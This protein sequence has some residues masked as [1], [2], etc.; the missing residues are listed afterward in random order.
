MNWASLVTGTV[1]LGLLLVGMYVLARV[2]SV[3]V[4][5]VTVSEKRT[6]QLVVYSR[7]C[8]MGVGV[9]F[10]AA[11]YFRYLFL[12]P[13]IAIVAVD[14]GWFL[15]GL[16]HGIGSGTVMLASIYTAARGLESPLKSVLEQRHTVPQR[17][18]RR[19]WTAHALAVLSG[20]TVVLWW[21]F[22]DA[23]NGWLVAGSA[24]VLFGWLA[25]RTPVVSVAYRTRDPTPE[26]Q[27]RIDRC[28][29]RFDRSAPTIV[30]FNDES[31]D[32]DVKLIGH[33]PVRTLWMQES[34]LS[35][36][37][38]DELAA[39]LAA[40]DEKN[41]RWFYER[42]FS[43]FGIGAFVLWGISIAL[44][45]LVGTLFSLELV[46]GNLWTLGQWIGAAVVALSLVIAVN[47]RTRRAVYEADRFAASRTDPETVR[48]VYDRYAETITVLDREQIR[49]DYQWRVVVEPPMEKRIRRIEREHGLEP[50]TSKTEADRDDVDPAI[51]VSDEW[52]VD[53][54]GDSLER[55]LETMD[56]GA[57]AELV[58]DL[59][60]EW[61]RECAVVTSSNDPWID[62]VATA[63]DGT[64]ELLRTVH[65]STDDPVTTRAFVDG[66]GRVEYDGTA[67]SVLVV[68]NGRFGESART[69]ESDLRMIDGDRLV[70]L[71]EES[72]LAA[73][74]E[75]R[76]DELRSGGP[77]PSS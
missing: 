73:R 62:V 4:R 45:D 18:R 67:D 31:E 6:K 29:D 70:E 75:T 24:A 1:G 7:V 68:T 49:S 14:D 36:S 69:L 76:T 51:D 19:L 48:R 13:V 46:A 16:G 5:Y 22:A 12:G 43:T 47:W 27:A 30:L 55:A 71:L 34:L 28:F 63:G 39:L 53:P 33:G 66:T 59:R 65:R 72:G 8:V 21:V 35:D 61:D 3:G 11:L 38:D 26:E 2:V 74:L 40:E 17:Y 64:R 10:A 37:S 20:P 41:S 15:W 56:P 23:I 77:S 42:V 50:P 54:A 60:A 25:L 9:I 57:F 32:L 58:A 52:T 44:F